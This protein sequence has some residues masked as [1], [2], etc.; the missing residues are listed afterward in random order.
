MLIVQKLLAH[1]QYGEIKRIIVLYDCTMK[2]HFSSPKIL[3]SFDNPRRFTND[4]FSDS[5][6]QACLVEYV[7][8]VTFNMFIKF[9]QASSKRHI[10]I[11]KGYAFF[12]IKVFKKTRI[13][14]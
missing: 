5:N 14:K 10:H 9:V 13:H 3:P 2:R 1:I 4:N 11:H 7:K 6:M 8:V 12:D